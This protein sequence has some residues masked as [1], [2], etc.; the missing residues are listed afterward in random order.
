MHETSFHLNQLK[1]TPI[2]AVSA[3]IKIGEI[4]MILTFQKKQKEVQFKVNL[5]KGNVNLQTWFT[6][7][8]GKKWGAYYA[9]INKN[10]K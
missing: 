6:D 7:I 2:L 9:Y 4:E 1:N 10:N 5:V 8:S 3:K